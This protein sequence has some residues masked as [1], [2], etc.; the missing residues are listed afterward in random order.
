MKISREANQCAR[1]ITS[2]V[3]T[4]T[5]KKLSIEACLKITACVQTAMNV[6]GKS[7]VASTLDEALNSGD[8]TYR[9]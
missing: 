4:E 8:G 2:L 9:P 1:A 5:G 6:A 3:E 7:A